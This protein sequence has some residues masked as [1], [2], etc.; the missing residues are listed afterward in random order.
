MAALHHASFLGTT[1]ACYVHAFAVRHKS[2]RTA[3]QL[4]TSMVIPCSSTQNLRPMACTHATLTPQADSG[5][6]WVTVE[7]LHVLG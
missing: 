4:P 2:G 3:G 6:P 1:H 5:C 7:L